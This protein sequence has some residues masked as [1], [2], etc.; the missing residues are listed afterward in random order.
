MLTLRRGLADLSIFDD[1]F[2]KK[3]IFGPSKWSQKWTK[4][5]FKMEPKW[6]S[7]WDPK[8]VQQK[9]KNNL[10]MIQK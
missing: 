5:G 9:F 2:M 3:A 1:S 6:S 10:R 4:N 7:K 8:W